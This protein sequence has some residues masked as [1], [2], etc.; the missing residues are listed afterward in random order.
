M[1][2][3]RSFQKSTV[4]SYPIETKQS[5]KQLR[6]FWHSGPGTWRLVGDYIQM[7]A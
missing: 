2:R 6:G 3:K 7:H 5:H 4:R 1:R